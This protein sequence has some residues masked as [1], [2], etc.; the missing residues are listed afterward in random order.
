MHTLLLSCPCFVPLTLLHVLL[1]SAAACLSCKQ[2]EEAKD[3]AVL[4][5]PAERVA[6]VRPMW[7]QRPH[8]ERVELLTVD[9]DTLKQQAKAQADKQRAHAGAHSGDSSAAGN[10]TAAL[11]GAGAVAGAQQ[12]RYADR[13]LGSILQQLQHQSEECSCGVSVSQQQQQHS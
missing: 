10:G 9:L 6:A 11:A 3:A 7:E 13:E 5:N 8:S 4:L 2:K 12:C 1:S